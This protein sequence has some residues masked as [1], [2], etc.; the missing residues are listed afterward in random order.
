MQPPGLNVVVHLAFGIAAL[1]AGAAPLLAGK[2][3]RTHRRWGRMAVLLG[4]VTAGTALLGV[5]L[6]PVPPALTAVTLSASYQLFAGARSAWMRGTRPRA[7]D[8]GAACAALAGVALV[9]TQGGAAS[10]SFSPAIEASALGWVSVVAFYDLGRHA[11]SAVRWQR[12][13]PLDHGLKMIGFYAA[14]ASAGLGNL[15]PFGQPWSSVVPSVLGAMGM[16]VVAWTHA[17]R[18]RGLWGAMP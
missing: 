11:L 9:A 1:L 3:G 5:F 15:L 12:L 7:L 18:Q 2:G 14:M 8:A 17:R 16:M 6:A 13:R 10:T 4:G